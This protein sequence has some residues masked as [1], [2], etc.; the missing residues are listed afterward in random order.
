MSIKTNFKS[1]LSAGIWSRWLLTFLISFFLLYPF[2]YS[3]IPLSSDLKILV[4]KIKEFD[5][6]DKIEVSKIQKD[7]G[8]ITE[9]R[10][11]N[12]KNQL[13]RF[14]I[15]GDEII[16]R[17]CNASFILYQ[18]DKNNFLLK[19]SRYQKDGSLI[20]GPCEI[21]P[22][23]DYRI[24]NPKKLKRQFEILNELDG[25]K[26]MGS[27]AAIATY[28]DHKLNPIKQLRINVNR[29]WKICN[30]LYNF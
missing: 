17:H 16:S 12:P 22:V 26:K 6:K 19:E 18:M 9:Y 27:A 8:K 4:E 10:L 24:P 13:L 11:K 20:E 2:S 29:Y 7:R 14:E 1:L 15:K 25:N 30:F 28:Y 21:Y 3:G 5:L 23:I